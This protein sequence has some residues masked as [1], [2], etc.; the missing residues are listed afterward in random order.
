MGGCHSRSSRRCC[1]CFC[2]PAWL[3]KW[4]NFVAWLCLSQP[5][6]RDEN[7][8]HLEVYASSRQRNGSVNPIA[9][10]W[11]STP[12][13]QRQDRAELSPLLSKLTLIRLVTGSISRRTV[14][15][16][17]GV[18]GSVAVEADKDVT[19]GPKR[20]PFRPVSSHPDR[21]G[22]RRNRSENENLS[23]DVRPPM[24][25]PDLSDFWNELSHTLR[26]LEYGLPLMDA[27]L[28]RGPS[29]KRR[30]M[31]DHLSVSHVP[32]E[33]PNWPSSSPLSF[34]ARS[35]SPTPFAIRSNRKVFRFPSIPAG[36][37]RMKK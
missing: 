14:Q 6:E 8:E 19:S 36:T 5:D 15:I 28:T 17:V 3:K 26:C 1:Y 31:A 27:A 25:H 32:A 23:I 20:L 35:R 2:C 11:F 16:D 10:W 37:S 7:E 12:P 18:S 29:I 21:I 34:V 30:R 4:R 9:S 13:D 33:L 22:R 24:S